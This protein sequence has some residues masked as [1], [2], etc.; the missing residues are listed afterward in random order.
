VLVLLGLPAVV[1]ISF[2]GHPL[3]SL[4]YGHRY[5]AAAASLAVASLVALLNLANGQLTT[6]FFARG[7]PNL[8]RTCVVIMAITMM[9]LI[10]P[11]VK[12][13][14]LVG[15]QLAALAA[16]AAGL[17]FQ[18][19]RVHRLT[20]MSLGEYSRIFVVGA[21]VSLVV[22]LAGFGARSWSAA[23]RPIP[24][25]LIGMLGCLIAYGLAAAY[26]F[27]GEGKKKDAAPSVPAAP[28]ML[29]NEVASD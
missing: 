2:C 20:R 13:F 27:R 23:A 28:A 7:M 8:H 10:Y 26:F 21:L 22:A 9:V 24:N 6:V 15:G 3:L 4:V 14:G 11:A 1:F 5:S 25:V 17:L 12:T 18:I 19:V 16:I 29:T